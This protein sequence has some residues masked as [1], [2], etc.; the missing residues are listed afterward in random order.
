M[1]DAEGLTRNIGAGRTALTGSETIGR[2]IPDYVGDTFFGEAKFVKGTVYNTRQ[3]RIMIEG[4]AQVGK[5][6][7]IF[8]P[9]GTDVAPTV[10]RW[11]FRYGIRV[12]RVPM[13]LYHWRSFNGALMGIRCRSRFLDVP[14]RGGRKNRTRIPPSHPQVWI[15]T[16]EIWR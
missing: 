15:R 5:N 16:Q 8:V 11:G 14:R 1:A 4:A 13:A 6:L 12:I 9:E 7:K 2:A 3:I 10:F